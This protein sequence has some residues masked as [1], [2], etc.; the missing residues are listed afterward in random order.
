M[1]PTFK[2]FAPMLKA[3]LGPD[4]RMRLHGIASSTVKDRHGDTMSP[5]ALVDM[6]RSANN[7]MTIFLNHEYRVPEDV[8]GSVER[9]IIRSHPQD[10]SIHDLALDIIVN[11]SNERAVKA[12]EAINGGTQLGLSIGAMIPDGGAVRDRKS[13]SYEINHVEL[14]ETSLVGVPANPRS[15]VEYAVKSLNVSWADP[16]APAGPGVRSDG[17]AGFVVQ[18]SESDLEDAALTAEEVEDQIEADAE[19]P[20]EQPE[21]GAPTEVVSGIESM[22]FGGDTATITTENSNPTITDA[23]VNIKTPY[24]DVSIDTGNRGGKAPAGEPSQEALSSAPENEETDE[25]ESLPLNPWAAIGLSGE[26]EVEEVEP[27]LQILEPTV[28]ASLRTSSDLLKAIT[29]ELIDTKKALDDVTLERDAAIEATEKVLA[30]TAEIL[31]RLSA[32]PVGRRATVRQAN[33]QFESLKS[34]YG[35]DFLTLLKKG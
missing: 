14:L 32:T 1:N 3:S 35:D 26:P 13:G 6:E 7:N 24:A 16:D 17:E 11:Q 34:V 27:A 4:N 9:A 33:E 21:E 22:T 8:A 5:S 30:N 10:A 20:Q 15:W 18:Y 23:T 19:I 31:A 25:D 28:V 2:I 29:R 12:W